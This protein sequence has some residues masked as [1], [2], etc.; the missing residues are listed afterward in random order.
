MKPKVSIVVPVYN[1]EQYLNQCLESLKNQTYKNLEIILVDD[2]STD[3]S[4]I[5]CDEFAK[6]NNNV[7]VIHQKNQGLSGARNSGVIRS[8]GEYI[9]FLDSDDWIS[10]E[11][12]EYLYNLID[13]YHVDVVCTCFFTYWEGSNKISDPEQSEIKC[14]KFSP[15]DALEEICYGSLFGCSVPDKLYKRELV[16]KNPF[17]IGKLYEDLAT[18]YKIIGSCNGV[19]YSSKKLSYYRRR[20]GSII[21]EPFSKDHL[22]II[23]A[24]EEQL[25]Y[26]RKYYPNKTKAA[27]TRCCYVITQI[28]SK[29]LDGDAEN[30]KV[31]KFL[32]KKIWMYWKSLIFNKRMGLKYKIRTISIMLGYPV[33]WFTYQMNDFLKKMTGRSLE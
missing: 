4:G 31:Y 16:L 24:A 30:R 23:Q 13:K 3:N 9:T 7:I 17:P 5:M 33:V 29:V 10:N 8:S 25:A 26:F 6:K 20:E 1:V 2:G 18:M 12:V 14:I 21:N 15:E 19:I 11:Y 27:E 28:A 22:F 32:K